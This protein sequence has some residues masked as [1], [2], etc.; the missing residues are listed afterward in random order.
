VR[1]H[2]MYQHLISQSLE[3]D[4]PRCEVQYDYGLRGMRS[5]PLA[6]RPRSFLSSS[7]KTISP[8]VPIAQNNDIITKQGQVSFRT[9]GSPQV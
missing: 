7:G 3:I 2:G 4:L 6:K 8:A 1:L 5:R 9:M